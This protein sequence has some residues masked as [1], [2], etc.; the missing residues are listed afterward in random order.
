MR[1]ILLIRV[2]M[3]P[4]L[5][6]EAA[7]LEVILADAPEVG[8]GAGAVPALGGHTYMTS[9]VGEEGSGSPKST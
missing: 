4:R 3:G 8:V 7:L 9:A 2:Q 6:R 1:V 5:L